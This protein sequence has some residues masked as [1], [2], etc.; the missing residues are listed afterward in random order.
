M[1]RDTLIL[2]L[3][4]QF[5]IRVLA[6]LGCDDTQHFS[7]NQLTTSTVCIHFVL[8]SAYIYGACDLGYLSCDFLGG[9]PSGRHLVNTL[10]DV[11]NTLGHLINTLGHLVNT[12]GH[13]VNTLGHLVNTLGDLLNTLGHL[14]NTLGHLVNTLGHLVITLGHLLNTLGHLVNTLGDLV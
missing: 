7:S 1:Y 13:L 4:F 5:Y 10:G 12:L 11:L 8:L 6:I 2:Q 14:I 9:V 3:T